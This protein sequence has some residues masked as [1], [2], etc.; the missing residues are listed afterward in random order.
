VA[1]TSF[2]ELTAHHADE[3]PNC[4][5]LAPQLGARIQDR[6]ERRGLEV[7]VQW[8]AKTLQSFVKKALRKGY[9][10][11]MAEIGDKAGVRVIVHFEADVPVVHRVVSEFCTI[12]REESKCD[13]LAYDQ[14]GYLGVQL[15]VQANDEALDDANRDRLA[16]GA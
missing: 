1:A 11:P 3:R 6:L 10:D 12:M 14:L 13:A 9:A 5:D 2:E 7:I 15:D 4:K 8:R 16:G